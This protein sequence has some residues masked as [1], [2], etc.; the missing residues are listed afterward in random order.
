MGSEGERKKHRV[1]HWLGYLGMLLL[2]LLAFA[3][4]CAAALSWNGWPGHSGGIASQRNLRIACAIGGFLF[5]GLGVVIRILQRPAQLRQSAGRSPADRTSRPDEPSRI[6][7]LVKSLSEL[8]KIRENTAKA[9]K[10]AEETFKERDLP[11][12]AAFTELLINPATY[13]ARTRETISLDGR[14]IKQ[15][16]SVELSPPDWESLLP[17]NDVAPPTS[18]Q[19]SQP[20]ISVIY[21][22]ILR[23]RKGELVDNFSLSSASG[24][25]LTDLSYDETLK[26]LLVALDGLLLA[27]FDDEG[28]HNLPQ[29]AAYAESLLL[30]IVSERAK[31]PSEWAEK[32]AATALH[33]LN[34]LITEEH[35]KDFERL[36]KFVLLLGTAYPIA[37]IVPVEQGTKRILLQ[38]ERTIISKPLSKS[39]KDWVRLRL[40]LRPYQVS[41]PVDLALTSGSYHLQAEGPSDQYL[42]EQFLRC[43]N[44]ERLLPKQKPYWIGT[45]ES[46]PDA[47]RPGCSHEDSEDEQDYYF[48]LR[49]KWGQNYAHLYMRSYANSKLRGI[50]LLVRFG[51]TPPGTLASAVVTSAAATALIG[52]AGRLVARNATAGSQ[53]ISD[54]PALFLAFPGIA[55]S[56]FGF[57]SDSES[58][59][60]TSLAARISLINSAALSFIAVGFYLS[61]VHT[62]DIL[63]RHRLS[64]LGTTAPVWVALLIL[65]AMN[66]LYIVNKYIVRTAYYQ[67]LLKRAESDSGH[68]IS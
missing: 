38:Y 24:E 30:V 41:I 17:T 59:L 31:V 18:G 68:A 34:G 11:L 19:R 15:R 39:L 2:A 61:Q 50:D 27:C 63:A 7:L 42:M 55:A 3:L 6:E 35:E 26:L 54:V 64:L 60:R 13:R 12:I 49:R 8:G 29:E 58:V 1:W 37:A 51:E 22:P 10:E 4:F 44:C 45:A 43:R 62:S 9:L 21:V 23:P 28:P 33:V 56:W 16:V 65:A 57:A 47:S 14:R 53:F 48:R 20:D 40:G 46:A 5:F 36:K 67:A 32:D 66:L 52:I 25:I